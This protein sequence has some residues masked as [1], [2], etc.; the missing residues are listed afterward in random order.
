ML[1]HADE[2]GQAANRM[3]FHAGVPQKNAGIIQGNARD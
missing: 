1:V 2:N 3:R